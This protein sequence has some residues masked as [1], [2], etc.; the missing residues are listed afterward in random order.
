MNILIVESDAV[1][2]SVYRRLFMAQEHNVV[3][4]KS[5]QEAVFEC[6]RVRPD[7]IVL[8]LKLPM[9]N[10]I[11]FLHELRSYNDWYEIPVVINSYTQAKK[12][13]S[14]FREQFGITDVLYKPGL[15][16]QDLLHSVERVR[17][18]V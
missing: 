9:Y 10:G 14:N 16:I 8:E 18:T 17:L 12:L 7:C 6:E 3:V 1:L 4:V 13:P 11:A 5:G 15:N 2:G